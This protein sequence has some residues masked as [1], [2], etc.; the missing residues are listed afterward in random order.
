MTSVISS[1]ERAERIVP[2]R[3]RNGDTR[4]SD[5]PP[6]IVSGY[7]PEST[8]RIRGIG[9][10]TLFP[11]VAPGKHAA[12]RLFVELDLL[13]VVP[14]ELLVVRGRRDARAVVA[15]RPLARGIRRQDF[16]DQRDLPVDP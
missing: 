4:R 11:E 16:V 6:S 3:V 9:A 13:E 5:Q 8:F 14:D 7:R 2:I 1:R 10:A 12:G 15:L